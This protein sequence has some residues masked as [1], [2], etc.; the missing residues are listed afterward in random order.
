MYAT[1]TYQVVVFDTAG[2]LLGQF[3]RPGSGPSGL[4]HPNGI[5]VGPD[6]SWIVSDSN[7]NRVVDFSPAGRPQWTLGG[8]AGSAL[9]TSGVAPGTEAA[10]FDVPRGVAR[11]GDGTYVVADA[12]ACQLVRV[13]SDGD[14][15][16]VYGEQGSRPA[17]LFFPTDVDVEGERLLVAEKGSNRVQVVVIDVR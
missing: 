14:L 16:G 15:M 12:L 3:G 6:S 9:P 5:A 11:M 13:D 17:E 1:D 8:P 10:P 4:D 2:K 7:N